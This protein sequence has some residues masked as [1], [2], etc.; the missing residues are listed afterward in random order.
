MR[1][2]L[3]GCGWIVERD[4][5]PAMLK[6]D[7]VEI[8]ATADVS[9]ERGRLVAGIADLGTD[10]SYVD[11]RDLLA[12]D[13]VDVV[14]VASPPSTRVQ[15]VRD[16]AA[17][18]K[19][20]I[21]EKPFALT[22]AEADEMIQACE[23]A[24]VSLWMYHNYLYYSEHR[25]AK[26]L[27]SEDAIGDVVAVEICADG[28]RPWVGTEGYMP[29]WRT[30]PA[31]AGGGVMM[32]I[33][34]HAVYLAEL[35]LPAPM[36]SVVAS[37]RFMNT[38]ADDHAYCQ[39]RAGHHSTALINM[40]WGEGTAKFEINGTTGYIAYVYD[41][42]MGYFGG[43]VRSVRVGSATGPTTTHHIAPGRTQ[44]TPELFD[45]LVDTISGACNVYPAT[46]RD[47]RRTLEVAQAAYLSTEVNRF[48]DLPIPNES[49]LYSEGTVKLLLA[50]RTV[51]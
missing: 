17:A 48:V 41:E 34:V 44:F 6:C 15:I 2:G 1:F 13:D 20:I 45:D 35:F 9:Q 30:E 33:G 22:L 24:G 14:S 37:M 3:I 40:T 39:M 49:E 43:P 28:S 18:G 11:Y 7:K 25:L 46:G 12:R 27:I 16:A 50:H 47:G 42:N 23:A 26:K 19:N 29:G 31:M 51:A 21:C 32:D 5:V 38:G 4:H 36:E 8:V 10:A